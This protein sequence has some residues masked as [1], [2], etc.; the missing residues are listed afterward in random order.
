MLSPIERFDCQ[1]Q[2][3]KP[4]CPLVCTQFTHFDICFWALDLKITS[5]SR[6][7]YY[8]YFLRTGVGQSVFFCTF[9]RLLVCRCRGRILGATGKGF[10]SFVSWINWFN[11]LID[12]WTHLTFWTRTIP[13]HLLDLFS[14]FSTFWKKNDAASP[15]HFLYFDFREAPKFKCHKIYI[16]VPNPDLVRKDQRSLGKTDLLNGMSVSISASICYYPSQLIL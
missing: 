15:R 14:T 11:L 12:L 4:S 16:F 13:G 7:T 1:A 5:T 3:L 8:I 10:I 9:L 2:A 6:F